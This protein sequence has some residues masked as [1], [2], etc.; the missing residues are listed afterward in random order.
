M[1]SLLAIAIIHEFPSISINFVL[2]FT[3]ADL[4][5]DV[6]LVIPLGMG[7]DGNIGEWLL[8]INKALYGLTQAS[9]NWFDIIKLVYK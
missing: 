9:E 2:T 7:V 3:Q 5:V 8:R 4:N 1:R 6:F